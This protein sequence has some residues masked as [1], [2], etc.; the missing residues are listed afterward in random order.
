[1]TEIA[2]T[3]HGT[4][5]AAMFNSRCGVC[6][7]FVSGRIEQNCWSYKLTQNCTRYFEEVHNVYTSTGVF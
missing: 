5:I 2:Y 3:I 4:S 6:Q 1:M 7:K